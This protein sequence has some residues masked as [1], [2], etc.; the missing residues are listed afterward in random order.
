MSH[1]LKFS[2]PAAGRA[3]VLSIK[4]KYA[5]LILQG[6]KTVEFRRSWASEPVDLIAIYASAPV[7]RIVGIVKVSEVVEATKTRLWGYCCERGGGLLRRELREYFKGKSKGY[8]VLLTEVQRFEKP[9][10]PI[11]IFQNFVP[12]QSFRYMTSDELT[13]LQKASQ[14]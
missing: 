7:Q 12:P 8:A 11:A 4:P 10:L 1:S 5:D 14:K 9:L 13:N 6:V 3:I 2:P